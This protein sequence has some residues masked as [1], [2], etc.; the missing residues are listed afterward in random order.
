MRTW[1]LLG[2]AVAALVAATGATGAST[3]TSATTSAT[4][5]SG[6]PG[7]YVDTAGWP[8]LSVSVVAP[9]AS[10]SAPRVLEN[11][12]PVT[13]ESASNVGRAKSTAIVVDHSQSMHGEALRN[14]VAAAKALLASRRPGERMAVYSAASKA[15]QLTPFSKSSGDGIKALDGIRVDKTYGTRLYDAVQLAV[16]DLKHQPGPRLVLV[17]TDGQD[18][19]SRADIS[20]TAGAAAS[21]GVKVYPVAI[22]SATYLPRTLLRLARATGGSFFGTATRASAT[23]SAGIAS[24]VRR[25]WQLAYSTTANQG[26]TVNVEV[27][28]PHAKPIVTAV[29]LP[30]APPGHSSFARNGVIALV[31]LLLIAVVV[32]VYRAVNPKNP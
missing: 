22:N 20:E 16:A 10:T 27:E 9:H 21:D 17:V 2:A 31:I 11:G 3:T 14:A 28:Q 32:I 7:I 1:I 5:A 4:A 25:T 26:D 18:T 23:A 30:G 8:T 19:T 24:D 15:V 12:I 29:K 13:L 6:T